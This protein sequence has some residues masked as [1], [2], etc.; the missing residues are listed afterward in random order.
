VF[1]KIL[2]SNFILI[3]I[4]SVLIFAFYNKSLEDSGDYILL[5]R[6]LANILI[7]SLIILTIA[8]ILVSVLLYRNLIKSLNEVGNT[9]RRIASGDLDTRIKPEYGKEVNSLASAI[10]YMLD[11]IKTYI[12]TL[13]DQ[14]TELNNAFSAIEDGLVVFGCKRK[15][16]YS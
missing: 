7:A 11:R 1:I 15:N 12:D 8:S 10:N 3:L 13:I 16:N 14:N 5:Q 9:A 2:V 4:F 6:D